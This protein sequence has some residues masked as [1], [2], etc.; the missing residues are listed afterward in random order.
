MGQ[1]IHKGEYPAD[2]K[3]IA[4]KVKK[5]NNNRCVRCNH[6]HAPESGY[7]LTVHHFDGNKSNCEPLCHLSVRAWVNPEAALIFKPSVWAV[8]Y[9]AGFYEAGHGVPGPTYHLAL[10]IEEYTRAGLRW[11]EW[12]PREALAAARRFGMEATMFHEVRAIE[13]RYAGCRFRSRLEARWAV[14]FDCMGIKWQY[15]SE[16]FELGAGVRYLPDF[17]LP[18]FDLHVEVKPNLKIAFGDISRVVNF[19]LNADK[20]TLLICG[21]PGDEE[22][23][24]VDRRTCLPMGDREGDELDQ[25]ED[26]IRD[27]MDH[28]S[29][30]FGEAPGYVDLHLITRIPSAN[31]QLRYLTACDKAKSARFEF[32][33]EG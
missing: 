1:P 33:E 14:W 24:L 23:L 25:A 17:F 20:P 3:S 15:E 29:V 31:S 28:G 13:T 27:L 6:G 12:A 26:I 5:E 30:Y 9:I 16:G 11:P 8:P 10:W 21:V 22:M 19:A 18:S 2:W 7:C 4:L 32:G